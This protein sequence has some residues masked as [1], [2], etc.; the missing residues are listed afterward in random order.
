MG[1]VRKDQEWGI[2]LGAL[3]YGEDSRVVR[4][5]THE[6]G[7]VGL[8]VAGHGRGKGRNPGLWQ[9]LNVLEFTGLERKGSEGL[10]RCKEVRRRRLHTRIP[11]EVTR[12]SVAFFLAELV[13]K[14]LPEETPHPEVALALERTALAL[15][16]A[17]SVSWL[18][19]E[20]TAKLIQLLGLAPEEAP[21]DRHGLSWRT[22]EWV[23]DPIGDEEHLS[24][25]LAHRWVNACHAAEAG[26]WSG[27]SPQDRRILLSGPLRYLQYQLGA[28]AH[29]KSV[30]VLETLFA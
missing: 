16:I 11:V 25:E 21:S 2:V 14:T 24:P 8:W 28:P 23:I 29:L 1:T 15:D 5:L 10:F 22:G 4:V 9:P 18:H 26:D 17:P 6:L 7:V 13:S 19:V 27:C 30:G 3:R 20:F 12:S